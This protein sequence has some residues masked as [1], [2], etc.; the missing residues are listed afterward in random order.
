[1]PAAGALTGFSPGVYRRCF[2]VSALRR[3]PSATRR[4]TRDL[5]FDCAYSS[6]QHAATRNFAKLQALGDEHVR[7]H[8]NQSFDAAVH[9]YGPFGAHRHGEPFS[10][11]FD[12]RSRSTGLLGDDH[13]DRMSAL[14]SRAA[15]GSRAAGLWAVGKRKI[16]KLW[17]AHSGQSPAAR[18]LN[19]RYPLPAL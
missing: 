14:Q 4:S 19:L 15:L 9:L 7:T 8:T 10:R 6:S 11:R 12:G 3:R 13:A 16:G 18:R 17:R 1:M 5:R 2:T